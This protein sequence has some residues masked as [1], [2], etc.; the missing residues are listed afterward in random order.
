MPSDITLSPAAVRT[1]RYRERREHGDIVISLEVYRD[2][3]EALVEHGLL[4]E[5]D[6]KDRAKVSDAVDLLLFALAEGILEIDFE[7]FDE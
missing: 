2:R 4:A 3:L 5:R 7:N 6:L 1:R